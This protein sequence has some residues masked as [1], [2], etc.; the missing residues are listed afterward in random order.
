[1]NN[2]ANNDPFDPIF[3][4]PVSP[5]IFFAL[6]E[7]FRVFIANLS[8]YSRQ[9]LLLKLLHRENYWIKLLSRNYGV[10][11]LVERNLERYIEEE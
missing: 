9:R 10:A 4:T 5:L 11:K 6:R 3:S 1:M 8:R 2:S 7:T